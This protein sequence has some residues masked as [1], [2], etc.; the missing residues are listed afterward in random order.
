MNEF[1]SAF[2]RELQYKIVD[3]IVYL[4][5][6]YPIV[7]WTIL[8]FIGLPALYFSF[9]FIC[10]SFIIYSKTGNIKMLKTNIL[11]LISIIIVFYFL[12]KFTIY[13]SDGYLIYLCIFSWISAIGMIIWAL[14]PEKIIPKEPQH[15][16]PKKQK[17]QKVK[18][19]KNK[20]SLNFTNVKLKNKQCGGGD[21]TVT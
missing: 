17:K 5:N 12:I 2:W 20:N 15:R 8:Y 14:R 19:E 18:F 1:F 21:D 11:L 6:Q 16:K 3:L 9:K 10:Y 7:A 13:K 4:A